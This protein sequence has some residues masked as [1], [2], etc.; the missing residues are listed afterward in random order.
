MEFYQFDVDK[1]IE[2]KNTLNKVKEARIIYKEHFAPSHCIGNCSNLYQKLKP[3]DFVDFYEKELKYAQDNKNVLSVYNRGLTYE[4]FYNLSVN[5]KTMVEEICELEFDLSVYFYCLVCHAIVETFV[6]QKKE[7]DIINFLKKRGYKPTKTKGGKDARYGVDIAV[8]GITEDFY[9]QIKPITF[10]RSNFKDTQDDRINLCRK[11]EELLN[12]EKIDTYYII[13][14]VGYSDSNIRWISK[15]NGDIV[16]KI[17]ELFQYEKDNIE[18]TFV[19]LDLP[20]KRTVI[21]T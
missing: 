13:Y 16:F 5:Y 11:R 4:E 3:V 20:S 17:N 10:F 14:N 21:I 1:C 9:L 15:D 7:E 12:M 8:S 18:E 2:S 19:R 6:G